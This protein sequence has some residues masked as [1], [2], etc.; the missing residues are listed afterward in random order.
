MLRPEAMQ[1]GWNAATA[2]ATCAAARTA[3]GAAVLAL[4]LLAP[5]AAQTAPAAGGAGARVPLAQVAGVTEGLVLIEAGNLIRRRCDGIS[6]RLL[7]G[8]SFM[9]GLKDLAVR[10]GYSE[11]EIRA[12][13]DDPDEKARVRALTDAWL[14]E[15]GAARDNVPSLCALGLAEIATGTQLGRL[16]QGNGS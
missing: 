10:A 7:A 1:Q 12:F 16:L 9:S 14:A 6:A 11:A 13:I 5:V 8:L 4:A 15:R 2:G 3:A